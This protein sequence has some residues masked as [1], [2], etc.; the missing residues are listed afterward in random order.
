MRKIIPAFYRRKIE[1]SEP[2]DEL[3]GAED[4]IFWR[5]NDAMS[6]TAETF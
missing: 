3:E 1:K 5:M 4:S 6:A 2:D